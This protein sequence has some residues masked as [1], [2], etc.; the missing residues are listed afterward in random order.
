MDEKQ[1][2][3]ETDPWWDKQTVAQL[4]GAC[5]ILELL[6]D[7]ESIEE[8]S[9]SRQQPEIF[10]GY[11]RLIDAG[12]RVLHQAIV[13]ASDH[14]YEPDDQLSRADFVGIPLSEIYSESE[15]IQAIIGLNRAS[16][17]ILKQTNWEA[18]ATEAAVFLV[19]VKTTSVNLLD[20]VTLDESVSPEISA[21]DMCAICTLSDLFHDFRHL[22]PIGFN[23]P[24]LSNVF[25]A[26]SEVRLNWVSGYSFGLARIWRR[27]VPDQPDVAAVMEDIERCN[28]WSP[29]DLER[30]DRES[31]DGD[32]ESEPEIISL[33]FDLQVP[34]DLD[35]P[36]PVDDVDDPESFWETINVLD[37]RPDLPDG[38]TALDDF[39]DAVMDMKID[40]NGLIPRKLRG[41]EGLD[42]LNVSGHMSLNEWS[43]FRGA[44][45][46]LSN[47][48]KL[49]S[50]MLWYPV[51]YID[52]RDER[53]FNGVF[54][55]E[56]LL[57]GLVS[58]SKSG[59]IKV[60]VT[61]HK[62]DHPG[63]D[64]S[65]GCLIRATGAISDRSG[66]VLFG[67]VAADI[68]FEPDPSLQ[69]LFELLQE[70]EDSIEVTELG[71]I[72]LEE[73]FD[74]L[75][76]K[77]RTGIKQD[78][79]DVIQQNR[80]V[81]N[82]TRERQ[83]LRAF[84][85]ELLTEK[86]VSPRAEFVVREV[87]TDVGPVD[88]VSV[89]GA[90]IYVYECVLN[91]KGVGSAGHLEDKVSQLLRNTEYV[92]VNID[93]IVGDTVTNGA[94]A[95]PMLVTAYSDS[96]SLSRASTLLRKHGGRL[97]TLDEMLKSS[98]TSAVERKR[99]LGMFDGG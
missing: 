61:S 84:V 27:L 93:E 59:P 70:L 1:L 36:E 10:D 22:V 19:A 87:R 99:I 72:P 30:L 94:R 90:Q 55:F 2:Q 73:L 56:A 52:A 31:E 97:I 15:R 42:T 18:L 77:L 33:G 54:A 21:V 91:A 63:D 8:A 45:H 71:E 46:A 38:N 51:E 12:R 58:M 26:D 7:A 4:I 37:R 48:Q 60:V 76:K 24:L 43:V 74:S 29:W 66:W 78:G 98:K 65:F 86:F 3:N 62:A 50:K 11:K 92:S 5:R 69:Y 53:I 85:L 9:R 44:K 40:T 64:Y 20:H 39:F 81:K 35:N 89:E 41:W 68:T 14:I 88:V 28:L 6:L 13:D 25:E 49:L 83:Q 82:L 96:R 75:G 23:N 32:P 57:R 16:R 67:S 34:E 80:L 79:F 47:K 95:I 17:N